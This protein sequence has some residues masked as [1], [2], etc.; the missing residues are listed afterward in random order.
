[1]PF[2]SKG[3]LKT[4]NVFNMLELL[5]KCWKW[6]YNAGND[7]EVLERYIRSGFKILEEL[8]LNHFDNFQIISCILKQF[9][10]L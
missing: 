7:Y 2:V 1:M 5:L 9:S 8:I 10:R 4:D 3:I 6:F